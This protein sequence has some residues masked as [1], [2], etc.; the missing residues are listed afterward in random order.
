M[1]PETEVSSAFGVA[2]PVVSQKGFQLTQKALLVI[3]NAV[4]NFYD[5]AFVS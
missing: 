3:I 2:H 5:V 4:L 1:A